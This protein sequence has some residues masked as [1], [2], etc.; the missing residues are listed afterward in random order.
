[1][2]LKNLF[3]QQ[4]RVLRNLN[5]EFSPNETQLPTHAPSYCLDFLV[6]VNGTGKSTVLQGLF[7]VMRK[8]ERNAPI[9]YGFYLEYELGVG[10]ET[11]SITLTNFE[12]S[13]T[14]EE[15]GESQTVTRGEV[16]ASENGESAP[17]GRGLLPA[18]VVAF[19]TGSED[20]WKQLYEVS[21]FETAD[22]SSIQ[23]LTSLD[24]A[25]RELPGRLL[26]SGALE[27]PQTEEDS[28][29]LL[30][31]SHQLPLVTLCGLLA[32]LAASNQN[33]DT[34]GDTSPEHPR[35]KEVLRGNK[36]LSIRSIP[37]FSL[38]FRMAQG[39]TSQADR[40]V[41][42]Q[43]AAIATRK[44]RLGTDYLLVFDLT[45]NAVETAQRIIH[46]F[47]DGLQLFK[48]LAKLN[49]IGN[50]GQSVLREVNIFLERS[51]SGHME[52]D[53]EDDPPLHLLDWLSDGERSFLGRMCLFALLG[54]TE[55][56]V[57]LDEPE[58]HFNDFWKRKIVSL[59]DKTLEG[60]HSHV[61]ITTHSSITLSDVLEEDIV[62]LNR[63]S[64]Y[65]DSATSSSFK[66]FA[67]DPSEIMIHI[68]DAPHAAGDRSVAYIQ[69]I[70]SDELSNGNSAQKRRN[71]EA[72]LPIVG[73]GYWRYRIRRALLEIET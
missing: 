9:E 21:P 32:D 26:S 10:E 52:A 22:R 33:S 49:Q 37:G 53:P 41:M 2:K 19:T 25:I 43:L 20:A 4:Y 65:T 23:D 64:S 8:I 55:A 66:T 68:F 48:T 46:E 40:K 54:E 13:S 5:I 61:L 50:D 69:S 16:L 38:K 17:V 56:L 45:N 3:L 39:I 73:E 14:N 34:S 18:L 35:L 27:S 67:A 11:R 36:S 59:L 31:E 24:L 29:F 30:I 47:S 70:L 1:M 71:L 58:V 42:K 28:R 6:G 51:I 7:D 15:T 60:K 62:I 12:D 57:L 44:I 63:T 72:L